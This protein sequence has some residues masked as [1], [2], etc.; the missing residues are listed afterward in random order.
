MHTIF[1]GDLKQHCGNIWGMDIRLTDGTGEVEVLQPL[2]E[3]TTKEMLEEAMRVFK[4][5]TNHRQ[6]IGT[7]ALE[8]FQDAAEALVDDMKGA[9]VGECT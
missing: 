3:R 1:L 6:T 4:Y 2:P 7:G 8:G 5:G 9:K